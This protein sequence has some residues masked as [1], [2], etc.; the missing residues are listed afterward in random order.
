M[1]ESKKNKRRYIKPLFIT[2]AI[3]FVLGLV[4][5]VS[6]TVVSKPKVTNALLAHFVP[7]F[8]RADVQVE[9]MN[10]SIFSTY[11]DVEV[12]LMHPIVRVDVPD[13]INLAGK[14]QP[15]PHSDTLFAADTIRVR[16]RPLGLLDN[17]VDI[18]SVLVSRPQIYLTQYDSTANYDILIPNEETDTTTSAPMKIDWEQ[19]RLTDG[20]ICMAIDSLD[21]R[22]VTADSIYVATNG[23]YADS[24]LSAYV[25]AGLRCEDAHIQ[26]Q[27]YVSDS[28]DIQAHLAIPHIER[29][30]ALMPKAIRE[31]TIKQNVL[32]G[33]ICADATARGYYTEGRIP[34]LH[35]YLVVDHLRGGNPNI[36]AHLDNLTLRAEARY[37]Q[38]LKDSSF[39]R[40]D[41]LKFKSGKSWLNAHGQA[42]YRKKREWLQLDLQSD[43]HLKELIQLAGIDS[44]VRARGS[45]QAD[46]STYFYL[47]DL[48]K[49]RI[50]DI[51]SS[52]TVRGDGVFLA[53]PKA[54]LRFSVDSL[55]AELK[56]NMARLSRRTGRMD[57]ALLNMQVAF[58]QMTIKH[59][60]T[61]N[62]SVDRTMMHVYADDLNDNKPPVLHASFSLQ[63]VKA[64]HN[65]TIHLW[66]KKLR[67]SAGMHPDKEAR[68]VPTTTARLSMDSVFVAT[69]R[70]GTIMDSVRVNLSTTPR[71]RKF[72]FNRETKERIPIPESEHQP[73]ALDSLLR[74]ANRV[75]NDSL[76]MES[77]IK[78]FRS[79]GKVYVRRMSVRQKGD[80]LRPTVSRM[81]LTLN[82][83]T[84]RLNSFRLRV[85]RSGISLKGEVQHLRRYLLRGKTLDANLTL[86]SRRLDLNQLANALNEQQRKTEVHNS[87]TA[88][89]NMNM[90]ADTLMVEEQTAD[91][92]ITDSLNNQLFILPAN[93]NLTFHASVDTI[94]FSAMRL[95]QFNGD[96]R[97]QDRTLS[98]TNMST[99]TKVGKMEMSFRYTCR[100]TT[101]AITAAV[102][103]MDS[104][105]VG[106][107]LSAL[108]EIDSIMPMLRSFD[109]SVASELAAQ[110]RLK[111]DLSIDLPSVNAGVWLR[112]QNLVLMDGETFSEIA[113]MLMFSKKTRNVIDSL[114]VEILVKN[115]EV[116]IFPF[117]LAMDKYRV[118]V[119]G[120]QNLDGSF[121]YHLS[122]FK[123]IILGLDIFGTDFD[124]IHFKLVKSRYQSAT[125][126]IGKGGSLLRQQ[127]ANIIPNLQNSIRSYIQDI[128]IKK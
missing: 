54:R 26:A 86:R 108:P 111:N 12:E 68:F 50:Y 66:A 33:T 98:V 93:L 103:R 4:I 1:K 17:H 70:I 92:L 24:A 38:L 60:R 90:L 25:D 120:K 78:R 11:P 3:A 37:N 48:L 16:I 51:H 94:I 83:D 55:R 105:Q 32:K 104:V 53:V 119:G 97:L 116:E 72:R 67:V 46:V 82:D 45:V 74:L 61:T 115:N 5:S 126:K 47:D 34:D 57:T 52:S 14:Y 2:A 73:M 71:Y 109:G 87:T 43:L 112:G 23:L 8:V 69:P 63:G 29:I 10:L 28:L 95:H 127:D 102:L 31:K 88:S 20:T 21:L 75:A 44:L 76:P 36:S 27:G 114:S 79:T 100:D 117:M 6:L 7:Q 15:F 89:E 22:P 85:G 65:D 121:N 99:S 64:Q 41:T 58:R 128:S 42:C 56:T 113:K 106:E 84:V 80:K 62:A 110:L 107:L 35:A 18:R 96:V 30:L 9:K 40:I 77:F 59:R 101:E 124:H 125:S 81:D 19:V 39:V 118:G 49:Q 13:S 123:P 122:V 91:S